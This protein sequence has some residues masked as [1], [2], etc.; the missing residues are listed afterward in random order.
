MR[1]LRRG[2]L[3]FFL[4]FL[5]LGISVGE[6]KE[7]RK[8]GHLDRWSGSLREGGQGG[9]CGRYVETRNAMKIRF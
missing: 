8:E 5:F 9:G 3:D 4:I 6:R 2:C 1:G 7:G